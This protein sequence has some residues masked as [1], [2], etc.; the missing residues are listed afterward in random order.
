[1]VG[2]ARRV[3]PERDPPSALRSA[4]IGGRVERPDPTAELDEQGIDLRARGAGVDQH[5]PARPMGAPLGDIDVS[6][7]D[8]LSL[9]RVALWRGHTPEFGATR[10]RPYPAAT[11]G[12]K[13]L[14]LTGAVLLCP[15]RIYHLSL[16][17]GSAC[18]S[19][20]D[21]LL[22]PSC[23][24]KVGRRPPG[25]SAIWRPRIMFFLRLAAML[26]VTIVPVRASDFLTTGAE[27]NARTLF[28]RGSCVFRRSK[29]NS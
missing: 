15:F 16:V 25:E 19:K 20:T 26:A 3:R 9:G 22:H 21:D 2:S 28:H 23:S 12:L 1:M 17:E 5:D 27:V 18:R 11:R 13:S 14:A 4:R 8:P 6:K 24:L 10:F 29:L 7:I